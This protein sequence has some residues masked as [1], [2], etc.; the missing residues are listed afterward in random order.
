MSHWAALLVSL[1]ALAAADAPR[2][3]FVDLDDAP[4][5]LAAPKGREALV[6]HFWATWC[7]DCVKELA[8]L[9]RAARACAGTP[10]RLV[11]VDVGDGRGEVRDFLAAHPLDL[12]ALRDPHGAVWRQAVGGGGLPANLV[13]TESGP[14]ATVGPRGEDDWRLELAR[15]G[16]A[17]PS[18]DVTGRL[19]IAAE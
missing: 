12:R 10:V 13:W 7:P 15:L 3:S 19:T 11:V 18:T 9:G 1:A 5:E 14:R 8:G 16:C 6:V 17:S 4:V 2:L